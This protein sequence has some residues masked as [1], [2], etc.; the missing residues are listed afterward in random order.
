MDG[1]GPESVLVFFFLFAFLCFARAYEGQS[2]SGSGVGGGVA[3]VLGGSS[4]V[5]WMAECQ[6]RSGVLGQPH[7]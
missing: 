4:S 1:R 3:R 5:P 6:G 7:A 2:G